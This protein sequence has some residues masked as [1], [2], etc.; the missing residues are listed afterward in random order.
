MVLDFLSY[1][2][3]CFGFVSFQMGVGW[4]IMETGRQA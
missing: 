1:V 2:F 4:L 3:V